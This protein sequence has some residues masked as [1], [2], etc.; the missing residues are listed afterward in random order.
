[1]K[2]ILRT[3]A[4]GVAIASFG[5]A[6]AASAATTDSADVTAEILSTLSVLVDPA[7]DTLDF[8]T[9]AD[10]GIIAPATI[11]VNTAGVRTSC[12]VGLVCGGTTDSPTFNIT[13]LAGGVVAVS[14]VNATE[15]LLYSGTVPTGMSGTMS[16]SAFTKSAAGNITLPASGTASF[17]VGGT[18]TVNPLQAPGV[19]NGTVSVSVA[20]N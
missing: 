14:F 2:S 11:V 1:M 17:T 6:S 18:L 8:G 5:I 19:Y 10:S 16:A 20:Y 15:P 13:G 7:D 12:G 9:I 4:A 3:A